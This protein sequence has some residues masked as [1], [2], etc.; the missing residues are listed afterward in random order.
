MYCLPA[1]SRVTGH[2][3]TVISLTRWEATIHQVK[4]ENNEGRVAMAGIE[5]N[6]VRDNG[7]AEMSLPS[8]IAMDAGRA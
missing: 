4:T 6:E 3:G 7:E 5:E 1:Q 8:H 2:E